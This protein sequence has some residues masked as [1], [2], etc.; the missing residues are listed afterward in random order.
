VTYLLGVVVHT[1]LPYEIE[2]GDKVGLVL[3]SSTLDVTKHRR[4][5]HG[6]LDD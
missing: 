2:V 4:Q 3:V 6:L 1:V 5:V